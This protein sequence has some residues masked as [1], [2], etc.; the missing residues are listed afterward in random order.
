MPQFKDL[1]IPSE[2]DKTSL[3]KGGEKEEP[4]LGLD[5]SNKDNSNKVPIKTI[6]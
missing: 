2:K 3:Y 5:P 4:I 1:T 6:D